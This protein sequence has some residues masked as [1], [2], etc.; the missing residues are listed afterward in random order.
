MFKN[1]VSKV[2]KYIYIVSVSEQRNKGKHKLSM[3]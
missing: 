3:T 2:K 1:K